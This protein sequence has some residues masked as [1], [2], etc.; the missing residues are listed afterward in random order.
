VEVVVISPS[1]WGLAAEL[2]SQWW[3]P[4]GLLLTILVTAGVGWYLFTRRAVS[5]V[6]VVSLAAAASLLTT[7][8][9]W[10]YEH[11]LL[12]VPWLWLFLRLQPRRLAQVAWLFLVWLIPW[13]LFLVAAARGRETLAFLIPALVVVAVLWLE[14]QPHTQEKTL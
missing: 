10:T 14:R 11:A 9:S 5:E 6:T 1:V 13:G 8:Y 4:L 2:A 7:P 12:Y 3:L